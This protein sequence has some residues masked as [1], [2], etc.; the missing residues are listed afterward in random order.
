MIVLDIEASGT[1]PHKHS[2]VSIGALDFNNPSNQFYAECRI[3][4]GAHVMDE[5]LAV[6]GFTVEEIN[7]PT[8]KTEAEITA[9]FFKWIENLDGH[10]TAGQNPSFDRD[11]LKYAAE[12]AHINWPLAHRTLD[13]HTVCWFHMFERGIMPPMKN[14]RSDLNSGKIMNYVGIPEEPKPHNALMGAKVAA[15][16]LSR[17][18][19]GKNLLLEFEQYPIPVFPPIK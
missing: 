17:L 5:A 15:E 4:D 16:A 7:D 19:N 11:F 6:N 2:I 18:I 13:Q 14:K 3:W 8:K 1:E 9:E 12:R 10:T